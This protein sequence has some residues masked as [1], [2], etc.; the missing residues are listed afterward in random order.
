MLQRKRLLLVLA[1]LTLPGVLAVGILSWRGA[2]RSAEDAFS[3]FIS[4]NNLAEDQLMDPL[5]LV[6]RDTVPLVIERIQE[7]ELPKRRYA[8]G[9]LGNIQA[10]DAI[11]VLTKILDDESEEDVVRGDALKAIAMIDLSLG[12]VIAR[13]YLDRGDHLSK[14]A[15]TILSED[16]KLLSRRSYSDALLAR[17]E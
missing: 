6:G 9:F 11:P 16:A 12:T 7:R 8:I 13:S 14:I 10:K 1:A 5:I 17:H 3:V 15:Q 4:S 2:F